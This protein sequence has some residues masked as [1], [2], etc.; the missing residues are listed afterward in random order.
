MYDTNM[1]ATG[2]YVSGKVELAITSRLLAGGNALDL[3]IIF[4]I[5]PTYLANHNERCIDKLDYYTKYW[6]D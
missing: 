3:A 5:Y 6:Q 2:R 4:D 1:L